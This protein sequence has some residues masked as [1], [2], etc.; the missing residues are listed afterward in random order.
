MVK[1]EPDGGT[2]CSVTLLGGRPTVRTL[3][4]ATVALALLIAWLPLQ[5]PL[6]LIVFQY[7]HAE[8][9]ARAMLLARDCLHRRSHRLL[10][11]RYWRRLRFYWFDWAALAYVALVG[12]Y[13]TVP[14]LLGQ[15]LVD[16]VS[17]SARELLVPVELYAL[18]GLRGRRR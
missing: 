15:R 7:G 3:G 12:V 5:T 10:L 2:C 14:W 6:A 16:A 13:S 17:A 18:G 11:A 9:L 8:T 1:L 4:F